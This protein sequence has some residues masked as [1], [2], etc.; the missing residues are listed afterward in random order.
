MSAVME[1][2]TR[3]I[4]NQQG[5][6][7]SRVW[8]T[9][10]HVLEFLGKC[11]QYAELISADLDNPEMSLTNFEKAIAKAAR[12]NGGGLGGS[13]ADAVLRKFYGLPAEGEDVPTPAPVSTQ[14]APEVGGIHVDLSDFL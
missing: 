6:E 10:E 8:H 13:D 5:K 1:E 12:A 11:P 4:R 9:G 14:A 2:V 3:K 7:H